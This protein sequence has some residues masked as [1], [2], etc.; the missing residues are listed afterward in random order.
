ML[1][2]QGVQLGESSVQQQASG[3]QRGQYSDK[4]QG[5]DLGQGSNA[6]PTGDD[7]ETDVGLELNIL[8]K[9]DGISYYA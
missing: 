7:L 3:Q 9:R 8:G 1:A 5:S 6:T 4:A 2:Q